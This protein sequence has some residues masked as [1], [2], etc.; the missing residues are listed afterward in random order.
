MLTYLST[1][2]IV[3]SGVGLARPVAGQRHRARGRPASEAR[4]AQPIKIGV[5]GLGSGT[6]A[7]LGQPFDHIRFFELDPLV[8]EFSNRYFPYLKNSAART[9]IVLGDARLSLEREMV[10]EQNRHSYDVLAIDAFSGD[11][12]PVHLITREAFALYRQALSPNGILAVHISNRYLDL[13]PVV[14]ASASIVGREMLQV[15]QGSGGP[16]DAIGNTWLLITSSDEFIEIARPLA[17]TE[18]EDTRTVAWT[19]AF[20]SLI[21][22]LEV[23]QVRTPGA[24]CLRQKCRDRDVPLDGS[25]ESVAPVAGPFRAHHQVRED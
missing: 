17:A 23:A 13:R 4:A 22:S 11:A 7:A 1:L 25:P 8:V 24:A 10:S 3:S 15:E 18:L 16:D 12:I 20:S 6:V 2:R 19:D 14:R 21:S 5:V 9:Q